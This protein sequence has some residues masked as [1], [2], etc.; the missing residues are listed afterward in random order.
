M[1]G[2]HTGHSQLRAM[3]TLTRRLAEAERQLGAASRTLADCAA[4]L[5]DQR[6]RT[7]QAEHLA[8]TAAAERDRIIDRA[9]R[10]ERFAVASELALRDRQLRTLRRQLGYLGGI[11]RG[12]AGAFLEEDAVADAFDH[13][14]VIKQDEDEH[15]P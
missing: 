11:L 9:V 1:S 3:N 15:A 14:N 5:D 13:L 12:N 7:E 2:G 4:A 10:E 8:A 6:A